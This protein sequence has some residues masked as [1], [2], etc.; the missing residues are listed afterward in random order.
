MSPD[1]MS[2]ARTPAVAMVALPLETR[3][4]VLPVDHHCDSPVPVGPFSLVF[5]LFELLFSGHGEQQRFAGILLL[6]ALDY[7][8]A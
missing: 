3:R 5:V 1:R 4:E 7:V 8:L 2:I 6:L